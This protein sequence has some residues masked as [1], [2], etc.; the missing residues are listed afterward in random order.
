MRT[1]RSRTREPWCSTSRPETTV[2]A[3]LNG[4][5]L[6][7]NIG[8]LSRVCFAA[9]TPLLT[10]DGAKPIE[11]FKVG[12]LLLSAPEDDP[13]GPVTARRVEEVF[14]RIGR[15]VELCVGGQTIRT[16]HE[17]PFYVEGKG[18]K[19]AAALSAGDLLRSHDG[20]TLP[21]EC[22]TDT[23]DDV[24]VYNMPSRSIIRTSRGVL[25]GG[26]QFGA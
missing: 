11:Q 14:Q 21:V 24:T 17:H 22:V 8:Q 16:T 7:G 5:G 10:P 1:S 3:A 19:Q 26:F 2:S 9:G 23:N 25:S 20:K 18:W 6:L 15:V 13:D 12:D 4:I